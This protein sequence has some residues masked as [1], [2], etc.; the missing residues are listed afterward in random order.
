MFTP[1]NDSIT[2]IAGPFGCQIPCWPVH[3]SWVYLIHFERPYFH[4]HHYLGSTACLESRL[5]VPRNCN[6]ARLM[7]V[8]GDAGIA[9]EVSR[10]W[11]CDTYE[12]ARALE[13]K[14]KHAHGHGPVLCPY[15]SHRPCDVYTSLRQGHWPLALHEKRGRRSPVST[16]EPLLSCG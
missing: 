13:R 12:E 5:Q 9:W 4:A 15:C 6:G 2:F 16:S 1:S 11:K 7:E 8:I 10:L 3:N 14:L